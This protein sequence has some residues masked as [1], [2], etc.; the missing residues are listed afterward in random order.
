MRV[1]YS[2][3]WTHEPD[4][5]HSRVRHYLW[6]RWQVLHGRIAIYRKY[7][8]SVRFPDGNSILSTSQFDSVYVRPCIQPVA[9]R[10]RGNLF[11]NWRIHSRR[12]IC[13]KTSS[14]GFQVSLV[15]FIWVPY[16]QLRPD[17]T[18]RCLSTPE[19][20]GEPAQHVNA[21][22][23]HAATPLLREW[24]K[25]TLSYC[26]WKD[27]LVT[28]AP[29]SISSCSARFACSNSLVLEF[30]ASRF[31]IYQAV[32]EHLEAIG[33]IMDATKCFLQMTGELGEQ[34]NSHRDLREWALGEWLYISGYIC[35]P[36]VRLQAM[37]LRRTGTSRRFS[38]G[39]P[40]I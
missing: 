21:A 15:S 38:N 34:M 24:V 35:L 12:Y 30:I 26:S 32:C 9:P 23:L 16:I 13:T 36:S 8:L 14:S 11:S 37:F 39:C 22:T 31:V 25:A 33:H 4:Y 20:N 27:V 10:M 5:D 3:S 28:A 40:A 19:D 6:S 7:S 1:Q 29:V 2:Y 18:Q 17:F